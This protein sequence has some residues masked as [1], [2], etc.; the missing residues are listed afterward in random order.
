MNVGLKTMVIIIHLNLGEPRK[1]LVSGNV[2]CFSL[3]P[4]DK[5][6]KICSA[7]FFP[8]TILFFMFMILQILTSVKE[9]TLV[10]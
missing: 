1:T 4:Q 5:K 9:I 7:T 3:E 2:K 10:T 8:I 6:T